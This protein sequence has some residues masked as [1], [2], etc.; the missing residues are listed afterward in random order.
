LESTKKFYV[1]FTDKEGIYVEAPSLNRVLEM[2]P[3]CIAVA[4]LPE[5]KAYETDFEFEGLI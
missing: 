4:S 3:D 5:P 1:S 2:Y